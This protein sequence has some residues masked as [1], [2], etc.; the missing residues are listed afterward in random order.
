M[1]LLIS[2]PFEKA[3]TLVEVIG[4]PMILANGVG[5]AL[6]LL[7][8]HNVIS[9]QE[10]VTALQAQKTLRIANQTLGYLRKGMNT[11]TAQAVCTIFYSAN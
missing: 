7:I 6:F 4:L 1:I 2:K 5:A 3:F 8:V 10:K 11:D 9:E